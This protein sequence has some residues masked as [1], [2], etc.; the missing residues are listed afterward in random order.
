MLPYPLPTPFSPT[1]A[2]LDC[3]AE[4][5]MESRREE[6]AR[7]KQAAD[8]QA[9]KDA[10]IRRAGYLTAWD[11]SYS[12]RHRFR[13]FFSDPRMDVKNAVAASLVATVV[14]SFRLLLIPFHLAALIIQV[15][16]RPAKGAPAEGSA[17][18]NSGDAQ[19]VVVPPLRLE[20]GKIRSFNELAKC[21][22]A[23]EQIIDGG[24]EQEDDR[25]PEQKLMAEQYA[26]EA[27]LER[28]A[29]L[30]HRL[31]D[32]GRYAPMMRAAAREAAER[33]RRAR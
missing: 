3:L 26:E 25:T 24:N 29:Q 18:A 5:L 16:L 2:D 4:A 31:V 1:Q 11:K 7:K 17:P 15:P 10:E 23:Y 12:F 33:R 27:L 9:K 22:A 28:C 13:T 19:P 14:I 21:V 30:S 6:A 8:E 32:P 20:L